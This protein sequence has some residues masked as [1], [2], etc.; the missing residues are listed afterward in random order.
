MTN[1]L[2]KVQELLFTAID[3]L[4][5]IDKK[6]DDNKGNTIGTEESSIH[7]MIEFCLEKEKGSTFS[8]DFASKMVDVMAK[9]KK[10]TEGQMTTL[11]K[12]HALAK[13]WK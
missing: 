9:Y 10:L 12:H 11:V 6:D 4:V 13:R 7:T 3:M 5:A 8:A 2:M 1:E